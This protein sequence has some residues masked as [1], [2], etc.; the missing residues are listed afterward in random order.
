MTSELPLPK[1]PAPAPISLSSNQLLPT[2]EIS[3]ESLPVHLLLLF[4]LQNQ[5]ARL[6][7]HPYFVS[8]SSACCWSPWCQAFTCTVYTIH[9]SAYPGLIYLSRYVPQKAC[10]NFYSLTWLPFPSSWLWP[11][12]EFPTLCHAA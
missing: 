2:I 6:S 10:L 11:F 9:L 1:S 7:P 4:L 3:Q 5:E 8:T 12:P